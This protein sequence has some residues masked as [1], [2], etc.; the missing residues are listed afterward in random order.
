VRYP[1]DIRLGGPRNQSGHVENRKFL[2]FKLS[3]CS[4]CNLFHFG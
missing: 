2:V 4:K 1:L 3:L